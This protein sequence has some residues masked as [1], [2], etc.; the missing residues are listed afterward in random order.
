MHPDYSLLAISSQY[1]S[2]FE[3]STTLDQNQLAQSD[4]SPRITSPNANAALRSPAN[5]PGTP[6]FCPDDLGLIGCSK[7]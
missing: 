4:P 2:T 3:S 5:N 1:R 6:L 7:F